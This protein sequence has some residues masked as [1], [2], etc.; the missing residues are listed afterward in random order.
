MLVLLYIVL[1]V[2]SV[3]GILTFIFSGSASPKD[4]AAEAAG[5][6]AFGAVTVGYCLFQAV[7]LA[8]MLLLGL[9]ILSKVFG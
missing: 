6:A 2:A 3:S 1:G 8:G 4:R 7:M 5:A 9:W